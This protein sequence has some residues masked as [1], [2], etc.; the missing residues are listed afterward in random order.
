M[1]EALFSIWGEAV[2]GARVL[3]LYCGGGAVA[4]EALSRGAR[5][6]VAVDSSAAALRTVAANREALRADALRSLRLSIPRQLH[7][8]VNDESGRFD[9][10]FADPPYEFGDHQAL[11]TAGAP[12]LAP[13][14]ELVLEHAAPLASP[15]SVG[16]LTRVDCRTYGGSALSR[17]RL[18]PDAA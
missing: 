14:G 7:R 15:E 4:L 2:L 17:Y 8:L 3:D 6:A 12:L 13:G 18:R 1:R 10:V 5:E 9:L 16:S 11:L